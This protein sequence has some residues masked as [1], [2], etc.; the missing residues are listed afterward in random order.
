MLDQKKFPSSV[1]NHGD[2]IYEPT[3][4]F[5]VTISI[6]LVQLLMLHNKRVLTET[7]Y[8]QV[9]NIKL[10]MFVCEF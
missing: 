2:Y 9:L 10:L 4:G 3:G 7:S 5:K 1:F 8:R 6:C